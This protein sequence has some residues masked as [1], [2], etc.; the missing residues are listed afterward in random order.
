MMRTLILRTIFTLSCLG[1]ST[2]ASAAEAGAGGQNG[3]ALHDKLCLSCHTGMFGGDGSGIYTRDDRRVHSFEEL[4]GQIGN[5][6]HNLGFNLNKEQLESIRV[7]LGKT[8]YKF[9]NK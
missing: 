2:A 9:E 7:Y 1:L 4:E 6:N 5:C 3:K 8:F